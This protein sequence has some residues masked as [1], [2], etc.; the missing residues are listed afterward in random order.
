MNHVV[1]GAALAVVAADNSTENDQPPGT[2]VAPKG[3]DSA[4]ARLVKTNSI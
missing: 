3:S 4:V 2:A 1:R